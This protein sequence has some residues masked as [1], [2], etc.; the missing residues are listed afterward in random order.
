MDDDSKEA[1]FLGGLILGGIVVLA[2]G[3][4]NG[5]RKSR[6]EEYEEEEDDKEPEEDGVEQ[7][8]AVKICPNCGKE[9]KYFSTCWRCRR[10]TCEHCGYRNGYCSA[11]CDLDDDDD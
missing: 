7:D 8:E 3:V 4:L 10:V 9:A 11:G 1:L 6:E 5:Y 2:T